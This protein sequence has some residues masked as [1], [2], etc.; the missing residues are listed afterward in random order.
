MTNVRITAGMVS[1]FAALTGDVS[2]L[3]VDEAFARRSAYR[4]PIAHGMLPVAHLA[5][6]PEL[7]VAGAQCRMVGLTG[8]FVAPVFPGDPLTLSAHAARQPAGSGTIEVD[9][10]I[11][12]TTAGTLVT[13]G[14]LSATVEPTESVP[15]AA[16]ADPL[17]SMLARSL[18][19]KH[20]RLEELEAGTTD[21][22]EFAVSEAAIAAFVSIL[23]EGADRDAGMRAAEVAA[24]VRVPDLL[25]LLLFSTSIGVSLP[26]AAATFLEFS[27]RVEKPVQVGTPYTLSGRVAHRSAAT[28]IV[29]KD[30]MVVPAA[31]GDACVTGRASTLVAKPFNRMPTSHELQAQG[32]DL[33]LAGKVVLVTGASRGIGET[34]AKLFALHGA[35]VIVNYHRGAEDARRVVDEIAGAGGNAVAIQGDVVDAASVAA[36][37]AGG[38]DRFGGIDVL[39]NNA[40]RDYRPVPFPRLTWD[41]I[42]KDIDVIVKGAFLCCQAVLPGMVQRGWGRI[43]NISTVA[44]D[45][46]PPDQTKYVVAKSAL[47]GLTRSLSIEFAH[48]GVAVNLVAPQF[49]E[50]DFVAHIPDGFRKKI[51]QDIPMQRA[52]SALDVARAVVFLASSY[53]SFTTGQKVM[54]TGGGAPY[55]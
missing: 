6:L 49:V 10:E 8:R 22:F 16:A 24:R 37:V 53:A 52:A 45:D 1:R 33:G 19:V 14:T 50:T 51:A 44:T 35:R 9:Y 36:M 43:V 2:S 31:G 42:Q 18:P 34:T 46:P 25:A 17:P 4:E 13:T 11:R 54:V 12:Q 55:A 30:L 41:E 5:L 15:T 29:K 40:A 21:G 38:V 23:S 39:V 28:R 48:K 27:A 7:H 3:H 26:G 32:T 20:W 47:V